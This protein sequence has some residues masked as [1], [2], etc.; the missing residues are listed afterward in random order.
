MK[1]H[2][3]ILVVIGILELVLGISFLTKKRI[4]EAVRW[5]T[6]FVFSVALWV[7]TN[8]VVALNE[9]YSIRHFFI[10][11]TYISGG[12]IV[13]S[14]ILFTYNFP[15]LKKII[16]P[17]KTFLIF[18]PAIVNTFIILLSHTYVKSIEIINGSINEE[19]GFMIYIF[20][21]YFLVFWL[22]G[23]WN[24]F[25]SYRKADGFHRWLLKY[26][27]IGIVISA[28]LGIT[29][30]II[31]PLTNITFPGRNFLGAEFSIIWLG[32][33]SYILYKKN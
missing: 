8:A 20:S 6:L 29:A 11:F 27:L 30:D 12:F 15:S 26:L 22:W 1:Y 4:G 16:S 23:M 28:A 25:D 21:T 5:Y 9:E 32:F 31:L 2:G 24:I 14:F 7:L 19:F 3:I 10:E 18:L 33:T 17:I 13:G